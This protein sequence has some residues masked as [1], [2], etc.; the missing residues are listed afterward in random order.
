MTLPALRLALLFV[1]LTAAPMTSRAAFTEDAVSAEE[2]EAATSETTAGK[3]QAIDAEARE[4]TIKHKKENTTF[5]V[6]AD[7]EF[8]GYEKEGMTLADLTIGERTRISW[9][10]EGDKQV[11]HQIEHVVA[12]DKSREE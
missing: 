1:A 3:I 7:C 6:S 10:K 8:I 4:I 2:T 11:V 12:K 9:V 5:T